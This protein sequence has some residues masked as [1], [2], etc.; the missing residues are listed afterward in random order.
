MGA[1]GCPVV[2]LS[3]SVTHLAATQYVPLEIDQKI[4]YAECFQLRQRFV[5][6]F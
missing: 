4:S 3:I 6:F 5:V 2:V 1:G